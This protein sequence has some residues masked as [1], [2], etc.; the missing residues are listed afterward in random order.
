MRTFYF[1]LLVVTSFSTYANNDT[2]EEEYWGLGYQQGSYLHEKSPSL[3]EFSLNAVKFKLTGYAKNSI[4]LESAFFMGL[5]EDE[6]SLPSPSTRTAKMKLSSGY[7][8]TIK[9]RFPMGDKFAIYGTLGYS[10]IDF[11]NDF[12][13]EEKITMSGFSYG[14]GLTFLATKTVSVEV[15]YHTL[16]DKDQAFNTLSLDIIKRYR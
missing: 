16:K 7:S 9:P 5:D 12:S 2:H 13:T 10:N 14:G 3:P 8:L 15:D 6:Q 11:K 1:F 4:G